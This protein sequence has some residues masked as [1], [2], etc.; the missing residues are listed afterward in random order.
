MTRKLTATL[1]ALVALT[2][3]LASACSSG[4]DGQQAAAPDAQQGVASVATEADEAAPSSS[5]SAATSTD[6]DASTAGDDGDVAMVQLGGD[7]SPELIRVVAA[8]ARTANLDSFE[9][10]MEF[11]VEGLPDQPGVMVITADGAVDSTNERVQ[12]RIDLN[13]IFDLAPAGTSQDEIQLMRALLGDGIVEF[14]SDGETVYLHWSLFTSLFGAETPWVSFADQG[15]D[16]LGGGGFNMDQLAGGP[17]SLLAYFSGIASMDDRG[18]A[19]IRGVATTYYAGT[20][21]LDRS[22]ELA[23]P[24]EAAELRA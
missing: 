5:N 7:P 2:A 14:I 4:G 12:M 20:L 23:D 19:T 8:A 9:F 15:S 6:D 21:D 11:G 22:L 3:M 1:L 16:A 10:A 13:A 24:A 17:A 18:P